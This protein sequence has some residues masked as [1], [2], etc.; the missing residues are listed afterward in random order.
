MYMQWPAHI[1]SLPGFDTV[2]DPT[3]GQLLFRG[4]RL[5]MGVAEGIP[6]SVSPDHMGHANYTGKCCEVCLSMLKLCV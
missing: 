5:R 4:P 3:S 1:L 6:S 2:L